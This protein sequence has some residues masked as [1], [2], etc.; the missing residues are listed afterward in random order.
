MDEFKIKVMLADDHPGM[1]A[2]VQHAL[3]EVA[4]ISLVGAAANSTELVALLDRVPCDVVVS[5]Y[6]MPAGDFGDGASLFGLLQ[7]R[8]PQ[9]KLVVLTMLDNA[10]VMHT[11]VTL[12][13]GG[14]VSKSDALAHLIPAIHAAHTGGKYYSPSANKVIQSIDWNRRGRNAESVLSQRESEVVRLYASGFTI[15]EIAER[16][17]RSKKTI[18]TQKAKAM[19]KLGIER[20]VDLF[21]YAMENGLTATLAEES[22]PAGQEQA[23]GTPG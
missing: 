6:S 3:A 21:R 16:L 12:G 2:G 22:A 7:R 11:L 9:L 14:I 8:Y 1:L 15:N 19:E 13:I 18:S 4:T 20:E 5:D 10:A 23:S 17:H